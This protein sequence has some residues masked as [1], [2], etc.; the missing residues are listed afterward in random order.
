MNPI[1]KALK[2]AKFQ[3]PSG[4]LGE[5]LQHKADSVRNSAY[6]RSINRNKGVEIVYP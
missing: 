1:D 5:Y 2:T 6:E 4:T 3:H